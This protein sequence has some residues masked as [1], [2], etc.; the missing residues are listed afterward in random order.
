[1]SMLGTAERSETDLVTV[2]TTVS[3]PRLAV[4]APVA[5]DRLAPVAADRVGSAALRAGRVGPAPGRA[6]RVGPAA[7]RAGRV[8]LT[9]RG[10]VVLA[11]VALVVGTAVVTLFWLS[12]A[13]GAQAA[14]HGLRPGAVYRGMS[15]VVVRPGE[16]LWSLASQAEPAADPR[17]VVQQIIEVN[18]LSGPVIQPGESLWVPKG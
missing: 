12:V 7:G 2:E 17:L 1:M 3:R 15:R 13:G 16:T 14:S 8:R 11:A 18:A 5:A 4:L 6:G 9:R 10:R